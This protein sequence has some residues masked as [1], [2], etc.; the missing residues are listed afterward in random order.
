L[1]QRKFFLFIFGKYTFLEKNKHLDKDKKYRNEIKNYILDN[2]NSLYSNPLMGKDK[3]FIKL[4]KYSP[5]ISLTVL[6]IYNTLKSIAKKYL[7]IIIHIYE[8]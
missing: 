2:Y 3:F 8:N 6:R 1:T 7:E 5:K 4:F